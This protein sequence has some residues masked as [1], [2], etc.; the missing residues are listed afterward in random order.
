MRVIFSCQK[1]RKK[2]MLAVCKGPI[3]RMKRDGQQVNVY[4][5]VFH[6]F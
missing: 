6:A 5:K 1:E 2:K 3:R 4:K